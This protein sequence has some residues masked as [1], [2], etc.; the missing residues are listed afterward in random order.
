MTPDEIIFSAE[1]SLL[2]SEERDLAAPAL[3]NVLFENFPIHREEGRENWQI[4]PFFSLNFI[5]E[6]CSSEH[7]NAFISP[8]AR[9][10]K[11]H[12]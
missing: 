7:S 2:T 9:L 10:Q 8:E 3:S 1:S 4:G 5:L 11:A 6:I 12:D